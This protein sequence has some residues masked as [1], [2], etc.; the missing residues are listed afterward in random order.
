M[1]TSTPGYTQNEQK[2][3]GFFQKHGGKLIG[4]TFWLLLIGSYFVY[5][6]ANDL[7]T[8]DAAEQL[9]RLITSS[10]LGPVIYIAL[11]W[12]R[13]LIFLPATIWTLLGGFFFGPIGIIYTIIGANGSTMVAYLVG[14][15]FG[16]GILEDGAGDGL[17]QRYS[18]RMRE[19]SFETILLMRLIFLPY[20]L[21][22]FFSG[23][24]KISWIPFLL[25]TAIGSIVGTISFVLLGTSYGTLDDL[26]N[27]EVQ[28]DPVILGISIALILSSIGVSRLLKNRE[29]KKAA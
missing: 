27:G 11:Y 24:L 18:D 1:T 20:D 6:R 23:F 5:V 15:Y 7:T 26:L 25:G 21:V 17:L 3:G 4:L 28:A 19:N 14:R 2:N 13:P 10:A 9:A 8:A 22:S 29:A 16:E 12:L